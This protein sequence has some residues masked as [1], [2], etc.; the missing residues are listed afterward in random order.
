MSML[1]N[2]ELQFELID[3]LKQ[4]I[5][6]YSFEEKR[7]IILLAIKKIEIDFSRDNHTSIEYRLTPYIDIETLMESIDKSETA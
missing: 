3:R 6:D 5:H 2:D 7:S 4:D 1:L